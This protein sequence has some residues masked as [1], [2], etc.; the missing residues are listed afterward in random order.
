MQFTIQIYKR[1]NIPDFVSILKDLKPDFLSISFT[2]D[3][4]SSYVAKN[5]IQS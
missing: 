5:I 3:V 2:Y 1:L 4:S